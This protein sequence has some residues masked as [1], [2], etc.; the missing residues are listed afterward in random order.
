MFPIPA[1]PYSWSLS[2]VDVSGL[3]VSE[4]MWTIWHSWRDGNLQ[5]GRAR[6]LLTLTSCCQNG[7][8]LY[9]QQIC[10][11]NPHLST[12]RHRHCCPAVLRLCYWNNSA[13]QKYWGHCVGLGW[14]CGQVGSGR[15]SSKVKCLLKESLGEQSS[16]CVYFQIYNNSKTDHVFECCL[17][18]QMVNSLVFCEDAGETFVW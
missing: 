1:C 13:V 3:S 17:L 4:T 18:L 7:N 11:R 9:Q 8:F 14:C 15:E 6:T 12:C 5:Q 10:F 2:L 16:Y